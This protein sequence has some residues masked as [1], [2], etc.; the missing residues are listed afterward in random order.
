M[1]LLIHMLTAPYPPLGPWALLVA[2]GC[3]SS[4]GLGSSHDCD[5]L[6]AGPPEGH[7]TVGSVLA[8]IQ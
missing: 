7:N 2:W 8:F 5:W 4:R 1:Y 3:G 6:S